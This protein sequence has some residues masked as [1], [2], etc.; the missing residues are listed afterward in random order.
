MYLFTYLFMYLFTYLFMYLL[1][2]LFMYLFTYEFYH[3]FLYLFIS[4]PVLPES[5]TSKYI[6]RVH[7]SKHVTK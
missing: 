4:G 3:L 6:I 2:Y 5:P 1:T 7:H